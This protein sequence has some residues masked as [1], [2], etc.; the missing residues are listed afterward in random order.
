MVIPK[1]LKNMKK[2]I[3]VIV[4]SLIVLL[5]SCKTSKKVN[6]EA[7]SYNSIEKNEIKSQK[8]VQQI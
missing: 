8:K 1:F 7:Y 3:L 5:F 6:C 2:I 4:L